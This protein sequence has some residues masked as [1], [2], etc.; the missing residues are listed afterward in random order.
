M[1]TLLAQLGTMVLIG[2]WHGVTPGFALWGLWHGIGLFVHNRWLEAV[3]G[4]VPTWIQTPRGGQFANALGI[5][6]TFHYV[7]VGWTF[8][9]LSTPALAWMAILKLFGVA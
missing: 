8:F 4:R 3:R 2:L 9:S 5:L 7:A 6:L 1:A